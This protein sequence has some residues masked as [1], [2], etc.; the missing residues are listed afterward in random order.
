MPNR[1][2]CSCFSVLGR[3]LSQS[4]SVQALDYS[5]GSIGGWVGLGA[6]VGEDSQSLL[7]LFA[8]VY[9]ES[10]EL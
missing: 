10:L 7:E 6:A 1:N 4:G 2:S 9:K 8:Q 5:R 3:G